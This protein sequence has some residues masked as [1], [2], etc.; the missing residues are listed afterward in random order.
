[1]STHYEPFA[2]P[3]RPRSYSCVLR[4]TRAYSA[5]PAPCSGAFP[6]NLI[7]TPRVNSAD[8]ELFIPEGGDE[9]QLPAEGLD[10]AVQDV[11]AG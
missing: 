5:I 8:L 7:V 10:V 2:A 3:L 4:L 1:M 9:S 6:G 11:K